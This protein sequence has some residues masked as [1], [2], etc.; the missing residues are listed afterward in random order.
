MITVGIDRLPEVLTPRSDDA[1]AT[2]HP[3]AVQYMRIADGL[4]EIRETVTAG[5]GRWAELA[6]TAQVF[7]VGARRL[8]EEA[9]RATQ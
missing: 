4:N 5:T 9:N 3:I 1:V 2:K 7:A 6:V 8:R